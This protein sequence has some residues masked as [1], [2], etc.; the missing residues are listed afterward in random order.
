MILK[1]PIVCWILA[2][3][4]PIG[5]TIKPMYLLLSISGRHV[6]LIIAP[7][8]WPCPLGSI[9]DLL[10]YTVLYFYDSLN[11]HL[12]Y[13]LWIV[14]ILNVFRSA[15]A[16]IDNI[17]I[18]VRLGQIVR[19]LSNSIKYVIRARVCLNIIIRLIILNCSTARVRNVASTRSDL[20]QGVLSGIAAFRGDLHCGATEQV[21]EIRKWKCLIRRWKI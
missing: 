21:S 12:V 20:Y 19:L 11:Y 10:I 9:G 13:N 1:R 4:I 17:R 8:L 3:S 6:S 2:L 18:S 5:H 7:S 14:E 15:S 16:S